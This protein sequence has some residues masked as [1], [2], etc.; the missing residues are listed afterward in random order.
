MCIV[1][2]KKDWDIQRSSYP[3]C[4]ATSIHFISRCCLITSALFNPFKYSSIFCISLN[5]NLS[6]YSSEIWTMWCGR[7]V[8]VI[9][10]HENY[11]HFIW[12]VYEAN[13]FQI[14]WLDLHPQNW[15]LFKK[16]QMF[17]VSNYSKLSLKHFLGPQKKKKVIWRV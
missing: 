15:N 5:K 12:L 4:Y 1:P 10:W 2:G 17:Y 13:H 11:L 3:T 6:F 7:S 16:L 14:K 8:S 9:G